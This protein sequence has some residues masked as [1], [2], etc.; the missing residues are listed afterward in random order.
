MDQIAQRSPWQG[1]AVDWSAHKDPT[2]HNNAGLLQ[3]DKV[4]VFHHQ[5]LKGLFHQLQTSD[6]RLIYQT[7]TN[8]L[9]CTS[10]EIRQ[11]TWHEVNQYFK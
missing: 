1:D 2:P 11:M 4:P 3:G 6:F 5:E 9:F 10:V 8:C 7:T